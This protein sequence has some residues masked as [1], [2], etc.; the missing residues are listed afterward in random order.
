MFSLFSFF[1]KSSLH[2]N[3]FSKAGCVGGELRSDLLENHQ[4]KVQKLMELMGKGKGLER[5][6]IEILC[7]DKLSSHSQF[8]LMLVMDF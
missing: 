7:F 1:N 6:R 4:G 8:Y 5:E 2:S 3:S